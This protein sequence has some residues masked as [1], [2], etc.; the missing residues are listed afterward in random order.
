LVEAL[1]RVRAQ[2]FPD[3]E[4]VF[5]DNASTDNSPMLAQAFG[6]KLRYFR[7]EI[8]TSLGEAR[9]EA[10]Q[11]A[12]GTYVALLDCDDLWEP[13]ALQK[14]IERIEATP[15][16]VLVWSDAYRISATGEVRNRFSDTTRFRR[17]RCFRQLFAE[18]FIAPSSTVLMRREAVVAA[19]GFPSQ[20]TICADLDLF[21]RLARVHAVDYCPEV[22]GRWRMHA[23]NDSHRTDALIG[24][25]EA[26]LDAWKDCPELSGRATQRF[27]LLLA[28]KR[29]Q[30]ARS[31]RGGEPTRALFEIARTLGHAPSLVL[32]LVAAAVRRLRTA[33]VT[34]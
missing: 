31:K 17:G 33:M 9:N 18:Q 26:I 4:I 30:C 6:P 11:R 34:T 25:L 24:E 13:T 32:D 10:L 7:S 29:W 19:G 1:A 2:T 23:N 15:E 12:R 5:W 21:L 3:W 27:Q 28:V 14:M 22:L 8:G 20:Y 16:C